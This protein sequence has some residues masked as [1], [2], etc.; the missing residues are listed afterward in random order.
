MGFSEMT[1]GEYKTQPQSSSPEQQLIPVKAALSS[2][3]KPQEVEGV[4]YIR[5]SPKCSE[6]S[7]LGYVP[8]EQ[9]VWD[10]SCSEDAAPVIGNLELKV[11]WQMM[12]QKFCH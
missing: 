12:K 1:V 4:H 6:P 2:G 7:T 3:Q 10:C 9:A 8:E 11:S 5:Q